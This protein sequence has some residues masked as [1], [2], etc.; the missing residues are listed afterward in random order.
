M[1]GQR[2][3]GG[4]RSGHLADPACGRRLPIRLYAAA[5]GAMSG[6]RPEPRARG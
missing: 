5:R 6:P 3:G 1:D 4:G 2:S